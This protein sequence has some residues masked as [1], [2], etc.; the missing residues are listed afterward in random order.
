M[1]KSAFIL[2]QLL[3]ATAAVLTKSIEPG[4]ELQYIGSFKSVEVSEDGV[5]NYNE[6]NYYVSPNQAI[7]ASADTDCRL[8]LG[9]NA[10]LVAIESEEE[11][12]FLQ[13]ILEN[14]G[15]GTTYWTSGMYD[16][17]RSV[18]RWTA[19]NQPLPPFSPWGT[20]YPSAPNQL[21]RVLQ[22]Y[23]NRYDANWQTV[24]G[25]QLHRYICEE[26]HATIPV[27]CYQTNDL[28]V[29]LDA[30]GSIG[31]NNFI[32]AVDF[33]DQLASAFTRHS[34]SR[35]TYIV[36]SSQSIT[37]IP[38]TNTYTPAE[39]SNLIRSTPYT[40]GGTATHLG[41]D[42]AVSQF[43]SSPRP[44]LPRNM[45]VLTDGVSNS[46]E[47]TEAAARRA[48]ALG[49]RTFSVGITP[50]VNYAEL[51]IIAGGDPSRVYTVANFDD[52]IQILAPLS[53]NIC[54]T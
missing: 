11:W 13:V 27:P 9:P 47:L 22:Y 28:A 25:T 24:P 19:N 14:Y 48:T 4:S 35:L 6:N 33:V 34:D 30:S 26:Q 32:V 46:L 5:Q 12:Q 49:I 29:V 51:L 37:R 15:F 23:T 41:I 36:Y 16:P 43:N 50:S 2:L 40:G 21:L 18:W 52:L 17:A 44:Q 42:M 54:P 7:W 53:Q 39:I 20:G 45:V 8:Q 3:L 31:A 10:T 1:V 38:L